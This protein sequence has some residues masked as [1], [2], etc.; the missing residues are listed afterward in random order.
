M[1]AGQ[2]YGNGTY[3]SSASSQIDGFNS[4]W[5]AFDSNM[6]SQW[7]SGGGYAF[8]TGVYGGSTTTVANGNNYGGEWLAIT[9]PIPIVLE[10]LLMLSGNNNINYAAKDFYVVG[11]ANNGSTWNLVL[12]VTGYTSWPTSATSTS[13]A[14]SFTSNAGDAN[15]YDRFRIIVSKTNSWDFVRIQYVALYG[16]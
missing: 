8:G 11:S 12:S 15:A 1:I 3:V 6:D 7:M 5:L 10:N 9:L 4:S 16:R 2:S 13:Q 14:V